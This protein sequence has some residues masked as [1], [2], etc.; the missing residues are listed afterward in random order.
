MNSFSAPASPATMSGT[1]TAGD[2]FISP[3][4]SRQ[5]S[6]RALS[7][8]I[9]ALAASSTRSKLA[10]E[11]AAGKWTLLS[12]PP[13]APPL[14]QLLGDERNERMGEAQ[15]GLELAHSTRACRAR[16]LRRHSLRWRAAPWRVR[17][18]SRSTRPTRTRTSR[19]R[20]GR[21]DMVEVGSDVVLRLLQAAQDPAV[22][23]DSVLGS[24]SS[25]PQSLPSTF[26]STNRGRSTACCR[27]CGS[28]RSG[29]GRS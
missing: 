11:R 21:S 3:R 19:A 12:C 18:T 25:T 24:V 14:P 16:R 8:A 4:N 10:R 5:A 17:G 9:R 22:D 2:S 7:F 13:A 26:I 28:P 1:R 23:E 29:S 6:T 27:N 20:R 15:R